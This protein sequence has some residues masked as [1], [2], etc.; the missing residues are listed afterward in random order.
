MIFSAEKVLCIAGIYAYLMA[1]GDVLELFVSLTLT[2]ELIRK[3]D[4]LE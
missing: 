4:H 1:R 3:A 2:V